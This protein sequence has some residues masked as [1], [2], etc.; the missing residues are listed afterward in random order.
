MRESFHSRLG[1]ILAA[2]GSAI[3]LGNIWGFPTQVANH[4]GAAF[5]IVYLA[6]VLILA[7]PALYAELL[8]GHAG[9]ANP[10]GALKKLCQGR[11]SPWGAGLGR[12]NVVG[13]LLM[14]SFYHIVA[15]WMVA[16]G[17]AALCSAFGLN[18]AA[19]WLSEGSLLRDLTF[20]GLFIVATGVVITRG[21][22]RGIEQTS[23]RLMPLLLILLLGLIGYIATL[24]GAMAGFKHYLIPDFSHWQQ[25]ELFVSAMGQAF[26]SLSIGLGG[27][28]IYGSYLRPGA[29]LG[30]LSLSVAALDTV[31]ALLAGLLIIPALYVAMAQGL[32]VAEQGQ[33]VAEGQLIF[34]VLPQLF[35]QMGDSGQW[36]GFAFFALLSI[37]ALTS[38]IATAEVPVAYLLEQ[39]GLKRHQATWRVMAAIA[40]LAVLLIVFFDPLFGAAVSLITEF[41]LPL[42]G[43]FYFLV[44]GWFWQRGNRLRELAQKDWRMRILRCHMRYLCPLLMLWVFVH[45][46]L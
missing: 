38:T 43:V 30:R 13:A 17:L 16:H 28:M 25:S 29:N 2:A 18:A 22:E 45:V 34:G 26:F 12:L 7:V 39:H 24:P 44:V 40:L 3:G 11:S 10:V 4:G 21:V 19:D 32:S 14:L 15:G 8:I 35:A 27:M 42:S 23:R 46:A 9:Q 37:A 41:Q 1:F 33:L 31:V 6:V 36:L 20:T 5:L